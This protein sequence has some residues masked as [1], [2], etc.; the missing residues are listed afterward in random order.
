MKW[1]TKP[2]PPIG[3]RRCRWKF[4]F[5]PRCFD[6]VNNRWLTFAK[7]REEYMTVEVVQ[8]MGD[9]EVDKWVEIDFVKKIK[10]M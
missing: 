7:I 8:T 5:L 3:D 1:K 4:L 9:L 6:G 2:K 10:D